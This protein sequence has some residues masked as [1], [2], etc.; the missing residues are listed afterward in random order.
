MSKI[1]TGLMSSETCHWGTPRPLFERL[2]KE[3]GFTVD[4]CASDGEE[5]MA[6]HFNPEM[7]GLKQNWDKEVAWMNPPYGKEI[8]HWA[9]KAAESKGIVVALVPARTDTKWFQNYCMRAK[10]IRF[11]AGRLKFNGAKGGSAPFPSA[12]VIWD[13]S[14]RAGMP[15]L[16]ESISA[17]EVQE[18]V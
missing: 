14:E 5:M 3:F 10:E 1:T 18:K 9:K 8:I 4:V 11:V 2:N 12:I 7:D 15:T 6:R 16:G 17:R 13:G